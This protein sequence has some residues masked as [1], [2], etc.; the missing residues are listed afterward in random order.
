MSIEWTPDL[1]NALK[2]RKKIPKEL[3]AQELTAYVITATYA[4]YEPNPDKPTEPLPGHE[5]Q[6]VRVDSDGS[7]CTCKSF[8][9]RNICAHLIKVQSLARPVNPETLNIT[10]PLRPLIP[11]TSRGY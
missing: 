6:I 7:T 5:V 2:K 3:R 11:S 4:V 8:L 10:L 9:Y 1:L